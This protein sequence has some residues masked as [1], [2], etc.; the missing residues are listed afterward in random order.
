MATRRKRLNGWQR[1]G[2]VLSIVWIIGG[3][4]LTY[5]A[6]HS[7]GGTCT[8]DHTTLSEPDQLALNARDYQ[9]MSTA[10]LLTVS[11]ACDREIYFRTFVYTGTPLVVAWLLVYGLVWLVRWVATGFKQDTSKLDE[12]NS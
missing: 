3:G 7:V 2:V 8:V 5:Q 11:R 4:L 12:N 1:I 9:K 6:V 10:G